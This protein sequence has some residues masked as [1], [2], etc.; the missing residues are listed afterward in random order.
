M[1]TSY[2]TC[3]KIEKKFTN[4]KCANLPLFRQPALKLYPCHRNFSKVFTVYCRLSHSSFTYSR[5]LLFPSLRLTSLR[6]A[7]LS[8]KFELQVGQSG[9]YPCI[10]EDA[11]AVPTTTTDR[12]DPAVTEPRRMTELERRCTPDRVPT[13]NHYHCRRLPSLSRS[14]VK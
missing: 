14:P 6:M 5:R 2:L 10:G 1:C 4:I 11:T 7:V 13:R 9:M 12:T 3:F 8:F